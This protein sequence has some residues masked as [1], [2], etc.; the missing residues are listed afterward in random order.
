[1][2]IVTSTDIVDAI[3]Q[4]GR[5]L[6]KKDVELPKISTLGTYRLASSCILQSAA[7]YDLQDLMA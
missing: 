3:Q 5:Q 6:D 7:L 2:C 1:M 4:T